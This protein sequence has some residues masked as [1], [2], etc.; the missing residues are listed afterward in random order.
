MPLMSASVFM[1]CKISENTV[2]EKKS[3][4]LFTRS[5][6][7]L[8]LPGYHPPPPTEGQRVTPWT[9]RVISLISGSVFG[10]CT[11]LENFFT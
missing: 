8:H 5:T 3:T 10:V 1:R 4:T 9:F 2:K 7:K 11:I 6:R